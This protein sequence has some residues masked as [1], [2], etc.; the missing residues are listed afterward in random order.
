MGCRSEVALENRRLNLFSTELES[1]NAPGAFLQNPA[2]AL[3]KIPGPIGVRFLSSVGLQ[4]GTLTKR[5]QLL[6]APALDKN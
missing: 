2:P 4:F 5:A 1:G 3:D 6:P